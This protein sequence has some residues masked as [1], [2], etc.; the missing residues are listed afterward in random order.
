MK[1]VRKGSL[2]EA[3]IKDWLVALRGNPYV[4][5]S[6]FD[7]TAVFRA[8]I[9]GTDD[10]YFAGVNVENIDHRLSTHGEEGAIS[11]MVTALG[12]SAEIVEGWVMGAPRALKAGDDAPL[13]KLLASCCGKCRQQIAGFAGADVKIHSL[14]LAGTSKTTTV[15]AFLPD[16]FTFRDFMP[17]GTARNGAGKTPSL[18]EAEKRILRKGPLSDAEV[19]AWLRELS[20]LDTASGISQSVV[21][22]LGNGFCVAGVKIEEAAFVSINAVQG[23]LASANAAFGHQSVG[24]VL[25]YTKDRGA[26]KIPQ[27]SFG[28][29]TLSALQS[30]W[31]VS[32]S[33]EV[34]VKIVQA[35]GGMTEMTWAEA[36]AKAPTSARPFSE[37]TPKP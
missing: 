31:Q 27:G 12:P 23:A 10:Y 37:R 4:P 5:E 15:G 14:S 28:T 19:V 25:V 33:F 7:V 22:K 6:G 20:S 8:R 35:D 24:E 11:A 1:I 17:E 29:L 34:P 26:G 18:E 16:P 13:A 2:S 30:L 21:V 32:E 36:C 3:D 9:G